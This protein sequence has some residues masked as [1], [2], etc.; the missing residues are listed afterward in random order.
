MNGF[1]FV[2]VFNINTRLLLRS[3]F[4]PFFLPGWL[5]DEKAQL[6]AVLLGQADE[7]LLGL[8]RRADLLA[9]GGDDLRVER[10]GLAPNLVQVLE[11]DEGDGDAHRGREDAVLEAQVVRECAGGR[12]RV[13][14]SRAGDDGGRRGG[15]P[16]R[17]DEAAPAAGRR[18]RVRR[19]SHG[20]RG[21]RGR[22]GGP[23]GVSSRWVHASLRCL[24]ACARVYA[25]V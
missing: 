6:V 16:P 15:G 3:V 9:E 12:V 11:A 22:H 5:G 14:L 18:E 17:G 20:R 19:R 2:S 1:V 23:G 24:L 10:D 25:G 13:L 4:L 8:W 21:A 7:T